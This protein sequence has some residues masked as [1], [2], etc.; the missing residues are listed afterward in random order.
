M[1]LLL[2]MVP[3]PL[4]WGF[5]ICRKVFV[6]AFWRV[7]LGAAASIRISVIF[8]HIGQ[9]LDGLRYD[10][11]HIISMAS[12]HEARSRRLRP[13]SS[14]GQYRVSSMIFG[15]LLSFHM[16][17]LMIFVSAVSIWFGISWAIVR[18]W[19]KPPIIIWAI[20]FLPLSVG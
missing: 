15:M 12:F 5:H 18:Y 11:S 19:V 6:L 9:V 10:L 16:K 14:M 2:I 7:S 20:G 13:P 1:S 8:A 4:V 3:I 17:F